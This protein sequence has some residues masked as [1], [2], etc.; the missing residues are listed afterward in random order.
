[1]NKHFT[2]FTA[3]VAG[4]MGGVG[5]LV[6]E[7]LAGAGVRVVVSGTSLANALRTVAT[8]HQAGGAASYVPAERT[9]EATSAHLRAATT[10]AG[11]HIDILVSTTDATPSAQGEASRLAG[12]VGLAMAQRGE[13]TMID[14]VASPDASCSDHATGWTIRRITTVHRSPFGATL[15]GST[16]LPRPGRTTA[17]EVASDVVHLA[18]DALQH[19]DGSDAEPVSV[20]RLALA[21]TPSHL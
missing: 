6:A 11:G 14:I 1:M 10:A 17:A 18:I 4:P 3:L 9:A 8:I 16:A 7:A 20:P 2:C 15:A 19:H 5:E 12:V 13:G 21:G